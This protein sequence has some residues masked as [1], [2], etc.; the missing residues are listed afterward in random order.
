MIHHPKDSP[1]PL[2]I[3]WIDCPHSLVT[4]GLVRALEEK[5]SVHH[6]P[7]PPGDVPTCVIFCANDREGLSQRVE[8]FQELSPDAPRFW[9]SAPNWTCHSP[10]TPC[11][12]EP[13]VS[14]T[15]R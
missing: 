8:F 11:R 9:S 14:S 2:G 13:P 3:V 15:P 5:A 4:T 1:R 12:Q 10:A 6:G 7:N